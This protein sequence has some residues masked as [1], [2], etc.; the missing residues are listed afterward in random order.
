M[1]GCSLS[2]AAF[3]RC[4]SF[5]PPEPAG[6]QRDAGS[7][8]GKLWQADLRQAALDLV[9]QLAGCA[10]SQACLTLTSL[11]CARTLT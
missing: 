5:L 7:L 2:V 9:G 4:E 10:R 3:V 8:L 6:G 11:G 1:T